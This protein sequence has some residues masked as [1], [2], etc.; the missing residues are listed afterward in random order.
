MKFILKDKFF[1]SVEHHLIGIGYAVVAGYYD[2]VAGVEAFKYL[3]VARVLAADAYGYADGV[4]VLCVDLEYPA[5]VGVVVE[6]ALGYYDG[7][8]LAAHLYAG[9]IGLSDA[10]V[11]G[12]GVGEYQIDIK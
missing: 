5:A 11:I 8:R 10:G 12:Q 4:G 3:K 1:F 2:F 6:V 7:L 9:L